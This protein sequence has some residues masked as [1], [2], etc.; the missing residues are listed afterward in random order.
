[1]C[2]MSTAQI[3]QG[4]LYLSKSQKFASWV[5]DCISCRNYLV[6]KRKRVKLCTTN[7]KDWGGV[8]SKIQCIVV[9]LYPLIQYLWFTAAPKKLEN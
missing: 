1:M 7:N 8:C 9:P 4:S 6:F 3:F 2:L 5:K